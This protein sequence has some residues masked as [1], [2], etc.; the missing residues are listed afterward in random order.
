MDSTIIS[1]PGTEV[2]IDCADCA[3]E[4]AIDRYAERRRLAVHCPAS[5]NNE[6]RVPNE[7]QAIES[8]VGDDGFVV[9][10]PGRLAVS[11]EFALFVVAGEK[12]DSD[13]RRIARAIHESLEEFFTFSVVVVGLRSRRTHGHDEV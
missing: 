12:D 7:I 10:E 9:L 4:D 8:G 5:T 11:D 2:Q 3:S 13:S 1:G 6:V